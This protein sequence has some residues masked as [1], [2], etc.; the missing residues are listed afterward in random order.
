MLTTLRRTAYVA[1]SALCAAVSICAGTTS[2]N[3]AE[4]FNDSG[5]P[6]Y[7]FLTSEETSHAANDWLGPMEVC[8]DSMAL[9]VAN[10]HQLSIGCW[11]GVKACAQAA[12]AVGLPAGVTFTV[13]A[14]GQGY[15]RCWTYSADG[16][17]HR[18]LEPLFLP[19]ETMPAPS[20]ADPHFL[21]TDHD[22]P[23]QLQEHVPRIRIKS[24]VAGTDT[25]DLRVGGDLFGVR[26]SEDDFSAEESSRFITYYDWNG[27]TRWA[28]LRIA[29]DGTYTFV[30]S[31][32]TSV[33]P[34]RTDL[35]LQL[36]LCTATPS[37]R[38]IGADG[39]HYTA[40][41]VR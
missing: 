40:Q 29:S 30:S 35:C 21:V 36:Q 9:V 16:G 39:G 27:S 37:I 12:Y 17:I 25:I 28:E 1:A 38:Y 19:P 11:D 41:L 2:A 4:V 22:S 6:S 31:S 24:A 26:T 20:A 23:Y 14:N 3:A 10:D 13:D 7:V 32:R 18:P 15:A 34:M 33:F 8:R 5:Q